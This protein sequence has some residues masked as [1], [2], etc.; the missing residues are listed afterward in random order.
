MKSTSF[1]YLLVFIITLSLT[2]QCFVLTSAAANASASSKASVTKASTT[3]QKQQQKTFQPRELSS[4]EMAAAGAFATAFGVTLVHPI[5]TIK[6]LQQS[7]EGIG[8]NMLQAT[9]KIMKVCI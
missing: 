5:D 9:N 7:N 8:L 1:H 6:T 3:K 2:N 4:G